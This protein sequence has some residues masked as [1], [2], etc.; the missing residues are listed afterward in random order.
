MSVWGR[1]LGAAAGLAAEF[2][3]HG[4]CPSHAGP[5]HVRRRM[6]FTPKEL[7]PHR[8]ERQTTTAGYHIESLGLGEL[9]ETRAQ[10]ARPTSRLGQKRARQ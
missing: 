10:A 6:A 1:L 7:A 4:V 9:R 3:A 5:T 8:N 2:Q